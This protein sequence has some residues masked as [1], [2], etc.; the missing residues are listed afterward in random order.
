M[1]KYASRRLIYMLIT[2][3]VIITFTFILMKNLPGDPFG[4]GS[5]KIPAENRK[6]AAGPVRI[7]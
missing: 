3:W 2:L 4:E 1:L 5:E 6:N 7:G